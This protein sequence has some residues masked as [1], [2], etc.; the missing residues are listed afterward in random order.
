[1]HHPS[2]QSLLDGA[3]PG[4]VV[5]VCGEHP[6]QGPIVVR[7]DVVLVGPATLLGGPGPAVHVLGGHLVMRRLTLAGGTGSPE[8]RLDGDTHGG[9]LAAWDADALTLDGVWVRGGQADWGGCVSGP[10][11]GPLVIRNS[12]V[13]DCVADKLAGAVWARRG[14]LQDSQ[15]RGGQAPYGGGVAVRTLA[16]DDIV[17]LPGTVVEDSD[18]SVQ[19]G[20]LLLTGPGEVWGGR[21]S[22]NTSQQGAGGLV[23]GASGVLRDALFTDNIAEVGG[24]GL[25]VAGGQPSLRD[26]EVSANVV[27]G[28][29]LP[30]ARGVG[31]G[32][33]VSGGTGDRVV[34]ENVDVEANFAAWGGGLMVAGPPDAE[35]V[36]RVVMSG[37]GLVD[38]ADGAGASVVWAEL[39][40][41]GTNVRGQAGPG[42]SVESGLLWARGGEWSDNAGGDVV[43]AEGDAASPGEV[44][45][46][47][48]EAGCVE[49]GTGPD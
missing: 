12:V 35:G 40:L 37:G 13:E 28:V 34:L 32:V 31:G 4:A 26:V 42:V 11:S 16:S 25:Y 33:W 15:V 41:D 3:L 30:D 1:V 6:V 10:R 45:L 36:P 44:W 29:G 49:D 14:V 9:V 23:S 38:N 27:S 8:A 47:C 43:P 19:G 22:T 24:G 21:F 48:T 20:G 5:A 2:L 46:R 7:Q 18:G 17:G 39:R